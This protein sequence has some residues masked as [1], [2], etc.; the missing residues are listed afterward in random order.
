MKIDPYYQRRKCSPGIAVSSKIRFMRIYSEGF[1][2]EWALNES[3][4]LENGD[5]RLFY[6]P[7]LPNLHI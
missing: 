3:G 1:A 6:P 4:V 2:V 7:Y 5:F